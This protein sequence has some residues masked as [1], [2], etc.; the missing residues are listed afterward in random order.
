M[1]FGPHQHLSSRASGGPSQLGFRGSPQTLAALGPPISRTG[2]SLM[3]SVFQISL[4][5][6][7][8]GV[9]PLHNYMQTQMCVP[10]NYSFQYPARCTI[11]YTQCSLLSVQS[12]LVYGLWCTYLLF[13]T[14]RICSSRITYLSPGHKAESE[15]LSTHQVNHILP[16]T[17]PMGFLGQQLSKKVTGS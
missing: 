14:A 3:F 17:L 5:L 10:T 4:L 16:A 1:R 8:G 6:K 7:T 11:P 9:N 13:T 15:N 2:C 12:A